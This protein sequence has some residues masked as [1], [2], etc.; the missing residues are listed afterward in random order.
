M[1]V[2]Y[3]VLAPE[4]PLLSSIC[5]AEQAAA[6]EQYVKATAAKSDLERTAVGTNN[7]KT[8]VFTGAVCVHPLTGQE[9]PVW[10]A[11]YVLGSYGTGRCSSS[12]VFFVRSLSHL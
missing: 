2:T 7:S 1:G 5:S 3:V 4:H 6:V 9:V 12:R 11:D 8:G 10:V